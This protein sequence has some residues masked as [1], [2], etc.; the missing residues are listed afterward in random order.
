MHVVV[1]QT[2][3]FLGHFFQRFICFHRRLWC[4][5]IEPGSGLERREDGS[6]GAGTRISCGEIGPA[7]GKEDLENGVVGSGYW[8]IGAAVSSTH[9][10]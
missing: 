2:V 1:A 3:V 5:V 6:V 8:K 4:A 10:R 7:G 9:T